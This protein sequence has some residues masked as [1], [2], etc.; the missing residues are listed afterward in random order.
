MHIFRPFV[1][2]LG[3]ARVYAAT[4]TTSAQSSSVTGCHTHGSDIYC[5]DGNGHEVLVS[6]SSTPTT[7]V[8]AQYTGC[9]SHGSES[10]CM[11]ADGNDVLIQEEGTE[12][13]SGTTEESHSGH[14]D[15]K[16][17]SETEQNCHFHAGVEHCVGA[18]ESEGGSA[19]SCGV[20][21]RDYDI[22]LR[23]GTLFVVLVTSSIG[24]FAPIL[25]MKLPSASINGV[26]ST[27]I[28]QF[29]TGII[30]ATGFIHLY[31][32]ANLMFTNDCLGELEY[33]AT[34]SAVVVAGIFIAF[35]LEYIGH[36]IIVARNSKK[37]STEIVS[38]ESESQQTQQKGQDD[39]APDQQ[40]QCTLAGLGHTHGSLDL[41]GP[42]SKFSVMV[43][44]AGILFHSI[45]I[46][47]TLV[48]A[49]DSFYK[50]LLVVIVFHQFFEG[51]ALGARIAVLPGPIFPSKATMAAAFS[52][53]T[54]IGM[55]IGLGVLNTF[56]GNSRGT[57]IALGTLDALSAGILVWV[58][59]VDMWAR[60]WVIEGGEMLD[61]NIGKVLT[62]GISF[63]S[64]LVLMGVLGKWA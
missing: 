36:R 64:G 51:L 21:S 48:V 62:G 56:N 43:M 53:I 61:A 9:H 19:P 47:L 7:G 32:H 12:A 46:G 40:Q 1:I 49:G 45:L 38:S 26:V 41:T 15:E 10:Y 2:S 8:P 27:V 44:E 35:L 55:A 30:I 24:V 31:T 18:G 54:P 37:S 6:A 59:V 33:E 28:K 25:L 3:I 29:G 57:L 4:P 60:D 11:D 17:S 42:N 50:T 14:A 5:I 52:L 22:P 63:V 13:E 34:T 20:R 58:G 16:S 23:I 39:H